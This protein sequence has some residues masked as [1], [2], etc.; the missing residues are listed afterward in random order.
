MVS[1][2]PFGLPSADGV[3][4]AVLL[5]DELLVALHGEY[6]LARAGTTDLRDLLRDTV[7]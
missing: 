6:P 1:D 5:E 3:T 4:T 2:Y 7:G